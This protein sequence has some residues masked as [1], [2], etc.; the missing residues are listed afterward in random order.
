M[1]LV[2]RSVSSAFTIMEVLIFN[3][4]SGIENYLSLLCFCVT[5]FPF[6]LI[7]AVSQIYNIVEG[8]DQY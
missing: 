8:C 1:T 7:I 4:L 2:G 6:L 5:S 3:V